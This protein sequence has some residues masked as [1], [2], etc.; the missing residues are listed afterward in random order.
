MSRDLAKDQ[1]YTFP[2]AQV[3][4][5]GLRNPKGSRSALSKIGLQGFRHEQHRGILNW[6][7]FYR[8]QTS[9]TSFGVR[10]LYW[11]AVL[12]NGVFSDCCDLGN[13][14]R[15][16]PRGEH[17]PVASMFPSHRVLLVVRHLRVPKISIQRS[18][19]TAFS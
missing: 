3:R 12:E 16:N 17:S 10:K 8:C 18:F 2:S 14:A 1:K 6:N 11:C 4:R 13:C 19:M 15:K 9:G 5:A 7:V